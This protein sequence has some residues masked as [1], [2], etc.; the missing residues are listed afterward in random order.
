[1]HSAPNEEIYAKHSDAL[2]RFATGIVGPTDAPDVVSDAVIRA[3][4]SRQWTKVEN[5]RAYLYRSVLNEARMHHRSTMR[6]RAREMR[7]FTDDTTYLPEVR[8]EVLEA[9]GS[10]ST[11]QRASVFLT[12]WEGLTAPEV[13]SR[14]SM[15]EGSVKRHLARA[16]HKLRGLLDE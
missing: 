13:A 16:R 14:L 12:Y 7:T 11:N 4:T 10:L 15:S 8:P 2:V 3:M 5:H 1:M 9:V 6:R